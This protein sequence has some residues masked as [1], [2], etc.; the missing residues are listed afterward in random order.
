M[1]TPSRIVQLGLV[2]RRA[3][4]DAAENLERTIEKIREAAARGA[5]IVCTQ[6][7]FLG[8]YFCQSEDHEFF[9]LAEAVPG[10]TT[11]R[12]CAL[13]AELGVVIV[14]SLFEKRAK[15]LYHNTAVIIDAD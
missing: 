14:A 12:L 1:T 15:G 7:L 9:K 11:E 6:E 4:R 2:Q 3:T 13:A 10:P 8:P 5:Q